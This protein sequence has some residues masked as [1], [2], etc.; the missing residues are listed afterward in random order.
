MARDPSER[1]DGDGAL[2]VKRERKTQKPRLYRVIFH[3]DDYT[4]KWFVVMVLTE[5]FHL[6]ETQAT[7]FMLLVHEQ[8]SGVIGVYTKDIAETKVSQVMDVAK[9]YG[10]PLQLTAEPE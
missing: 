10:M 8:G 5:F 3:N 4:T 2:A 9:E 7:A 6:S 1:E